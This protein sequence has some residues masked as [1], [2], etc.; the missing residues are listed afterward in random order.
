MKNLP[1]WFPNKNNIIWYVLLI[2]LFIL[3]LDFWGWD[4]S[5]PLILGLPIWIVYLFILT[6]STSIIFYLFTKTFWEDSQ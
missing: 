4:Q 1:F 3:S 5:N 2:G 6:L